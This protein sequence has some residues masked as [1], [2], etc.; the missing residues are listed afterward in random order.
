MG[1]NTA[2]ASQLIPYL[3]MTNDIL[4]Q[5]SPRVCDLWTLCSELNGWISK[6]QG[7]GECPTVREGRC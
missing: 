4:L 6:T 2:P 3:E 1:S 5:Q 7:F